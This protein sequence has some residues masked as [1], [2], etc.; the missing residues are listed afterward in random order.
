MTRLGVTAG[1]C[2]AA[3]T[4]AVAGTF[5]H[6]ATARMGGMDIPFGVVIALAGLAAVMVIAHAS[7]PSRADKAI[8]AVGWLAP[9]FVLSQARSAGDLVVAADLRGLVFLYGGV[10]LVGI[11][12]GL[13][14]VRR[15]Q[16]TG[17]NDRVR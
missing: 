1:L 9:V 3:F 7:V 4:A 10:L 5:V 16:K 14:V 11:F 12:V 8:V 15:P 6:P 17:A 2:V 13:P